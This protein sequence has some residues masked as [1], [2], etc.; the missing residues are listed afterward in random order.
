M[1]TEIR[2]AVTSGRSEFTGK[3]HEGTT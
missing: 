3:E 1:I 2:T